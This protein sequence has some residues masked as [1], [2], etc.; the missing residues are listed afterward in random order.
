MRLMH[1]GKYKGDAVVLVAT[2]IVLQRA[3][4]S[5]PLS[6]TL[7]EVK[8]SVQNS[9]GCLYVGVMAGVFQFDHVRVRDQLGQ[10]FAM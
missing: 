6:P 2:R 1:A 8:V 10:C 3:S 4:L 7:P 5:G 9:L